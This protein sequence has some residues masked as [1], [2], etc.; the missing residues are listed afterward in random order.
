MMSKAK[1]GYAGE[2][3]HVSLSTGQEYML[4]K[5]RS[6]NFTGNNFILV[7]VFG[8]ILSIIIPRLKS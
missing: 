8:D 2:Y 5:I 4:N 7:R 6:L 1:A 3:V